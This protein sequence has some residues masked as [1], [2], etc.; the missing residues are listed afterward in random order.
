M[1]E[2]TL[3]PVTYFQWRDGRIIRTNCAPGIC[4]IASHPAA[5]TAVKKPLWAWDRSLGVWIHYDS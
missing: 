2:D 4:S 1:N 5:I 3:M